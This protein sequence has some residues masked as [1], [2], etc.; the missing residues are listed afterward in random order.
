MH[1]KLGEVDPA[2]EECRKAVALLKEITGGKTGHL[3]RGQAYEYLGYAY[4]ALAASPQASARETRQRM[5]AA[6][7]MFQQ[8][9]N[10]LDDLRSRGPL[11]S[12][13]Q[14]ANEIAGEIVKCDMAL[15]K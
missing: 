10:I 2:L 15:G 6:R 9:L 12:N 13:E 14:W 8:T 3:G 5:T 11:G 4:V 1:A 7:D